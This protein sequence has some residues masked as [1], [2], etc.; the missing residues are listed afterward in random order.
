M[1]K[2]IIFITSLLLIGVT[3][4]N[5]SITQSSNTTE[6]SYELITAMA[7]AYDE[8]EGGGVEACVDAIWYTEYYIRDFL[9]ER[10]C[11]LNGLQ[12]GIHKPC[13][14]VEDPLDGCLHITCKISDPE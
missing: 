5:L 4:L 11:L 7:K 6:L 10:P 1:K 2:T 9:A 12:C 14:Q 8:G 3:T 13:K